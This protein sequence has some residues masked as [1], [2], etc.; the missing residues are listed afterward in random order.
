MPPASAVR[1]GDTADVKVR[2]E[3]VSRR[4]GSGADATLAIDD[5]SLDVRAGAITCLLGPS[6]C[7]KSTLHRMV[8]GFV[9]Q[10]SGR[11]AVH[12]K[13]VTGPG[14][15]RVMVFQQPV[16]LPWQT[17]L[18]NVRFGLKSRNVEADRR[19][20]DLLAEIDL[21]N[22]KNH[23]PYQLSGGMRQRVQIARAL[24]MQ[25]EVLLLDE[26]F[27]ALDAQT[28]LNMQGMLQRIFMRYHPTILFVT[29]DVA[30]SLFLADTVCVMS[31]RPG[32]IRRQFAIP[33]PRPRSMRIFE[34]PAFGRLQAE[35]LGLL[36][37]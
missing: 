1:H 8:A 29:H 15:D 27:G 13:P 37:L 16:L 5:L 18:A 12:G 11:I 3:N 31:A 14:R 28:R 4:F 32:R 35:I 25:P 6:G 26:P 30:E 36:G 20:D 7:G 19:I 10:G 22:F 17:V 24:I 23:Y 9:K 21:Q 2:L 34:E 33:W